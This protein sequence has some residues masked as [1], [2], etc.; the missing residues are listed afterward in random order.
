MKKLNDVAYTYDGYK[1]V[2]RVTGADRP[3]IMFDMGRGK[4]DD[5]FDAS[6]F[7]SAS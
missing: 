7:L 2:Y 4:R 5:I 1:R 3:L 6:S